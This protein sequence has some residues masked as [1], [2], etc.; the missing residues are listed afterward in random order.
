MNLYDRAIA[1]CASMIGD[2]P[3]V[4]YPVRE[5]EPL[6]EQE[7]EE[8]ILFRK[9]M[10][11]ELGGGGLSA[12]SGVAFTS[13]E[14][15]KD[16]VIVCGPDLPA[17]REDSPYARLTVLRVDDASWADNGQAYRVMSRLEHTRY[18][19]RPRGFMMRISASAHREPVRVGRAQLDEGL[20]F[21]KVGKLLIAAYH[22][23]PEV[24]GA[25]IYFITEK[26]FPFDVFGEE[27]KKMGSITESMNEIFQNLIMDCAAC[28]LKPVCDEVEG[29]RELHFSRQPKKPSL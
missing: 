15:V 20:D 14:T 10:V 23:H 5:G 13:D 25:R 4:R 21:E 19:V 11:Y 9:D 27:I 24:L 26:N 18:H 7:T 12:V 28:R 1:R 6:W 16:E 29:L 8:R 2:F 17:L 22:E 3:T